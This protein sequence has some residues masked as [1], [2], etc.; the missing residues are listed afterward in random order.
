MALF[1]F[2][3]AGH[4]RLLRKNLSAGHKFYISGMMFGLCMARILASLMRIIWATKSNNVRIS[5]AAS[6]FIV[7][8]NLIGFIVDLLFAQRIL[9]ATHPKIGW[10]PLTYR[11]FAAVFIAIPISV[12]IL[13]GFIVSSYYT[14]NRHKLLMSR[15]AGYYGA[16]FFGF[17]AILPL[18]II[19]IALLTARK[20]RIEN[21]GS[22]SFMSKVVITL[23]GTFVFSLGAW[24]RAGTSY[25][26]P[27]F[28][29]KPA[30]YQSRACFYVFY[31][32]LEIIVVWTYLLVRIDQRFWVP[33][34]SKRPGD[35]SRGRGTVINVPESMELTKR[36]EGA[37]QSRGET[38][39][40][41]GHG[42]RSSVERLV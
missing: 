16:T 25:L 15:D 37:N 40:E 20:S 26:P 29:N 34:G 22:G 24:F 10:H 23:F 8:G 30:P 17:V 38:E 12:S 3:A 32:T 6:I 27:H 21:F 42:K 36:G 4:M 5:I 11:F 18:P 7:I 19:L 13:V 39:K 2:G 14:L 28:K 1:I 41:S 33:D 35:Y 9:R 31:F